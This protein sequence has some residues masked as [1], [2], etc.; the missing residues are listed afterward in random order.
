VVDQE[1]ALLCA[2]LGAEPWY[3]Q[4]AGGNASQKRDGMLIV[5][6]SGRRLDQALQPA[7]WTVLRLAEARQIA[8][9]GG[10]D[11]TAAMLGPARA[12]IETGLHALSTSRLVLHL[13]FV[14]A[15]AEAIRCDGE[16]R[17]GALLAGLDWAWVRYA[18][19]GAPLAAACLSRPAPIMLL[20]RHGIVLNGE[21]TQQ[22]SALLAGLEARLAARPDRC[23]LPANHRLAR[24][25]PCFPDQ[26]VFLGPEPI[27]AG[28]A[29]VVTGADGLLHAAPGASP[30]A[31]DQLAA[32]ALLA[33]LVP[34]DAPIAVL[35]DGE[36]AALSTWDAEHYRRAIALAAD[37]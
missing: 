10:E 27:A 16:A 6:A 33:P 31:C 25:P 32:L 1:F 9:A 28:L 15:L 12:S 35:P 24:L 4:G 5:K 13:H 20:D 36:A 17:L 7:A 8:L 30:G 21:D 3:T 23:G 2:R 19:P 29:P 14:P 26:A 18:R 22:I 34:P 37:S 11:F